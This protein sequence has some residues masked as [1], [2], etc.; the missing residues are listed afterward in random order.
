MRISSLTLAI[1]GLTTGAFAGQLIGI[2]S[3]R[4]LF[5]I[6]MA[7]GVRTPL[8][9]V[10]SNAGTTGALTR[11]S[12]SGTIYL[13]STSLDSLFTLDLGTL[14]ATLVGFYGSS[15]VVMHGLEWDSSLSTLFGGSNGD[16]FSIDPMTGV[17][18]QVAASGL[19][20]FTNLGYVPGADVMYLTNSITDSLYTVDRMTGAVTLIGPLGP[21]STAPQEL[22]YDTDNGVMYLIDNSTDN[23]CTVDLVTGVA[24]LVGYMGSSNMLGMVYIPNGPAPVTP[25]CF[26][27]GS[28]TACPCGNAGA[29][30]NGC[31]SSVNVNG[32]NLT[33]SGS[34]S[35]AVDTL[36]LQGSGMPNSSALYFQGTGQ[37]SGGAGAV[38]GDGLRCAGG[39]VVRLGTKN[40]MS[41][42]SAY[43]NMGDPTVSV[44]GMCAAADV[45]TYQVWY[46][47]AAAF[48]TASTFNLT[49]GIEVTWTP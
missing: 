18:T 23:L 42:A 29:A 13:S 9:Q 48:C 22:A 10:S 35:I 11:D 37:Q 33:A 14:N 21:A 41:G 1:C 12:S 26:G 3:S 7:T 46:R 40:N 34:P 19:T 25:F 17:A 30:G 2:D 15:T 44:R 24:T 31:A 43:P 28:G 45:R 36:V 27:D 39:S 49:N 6:D 16:L 4:N 32:G 8:G 5:D 47:N 38:F 20:S